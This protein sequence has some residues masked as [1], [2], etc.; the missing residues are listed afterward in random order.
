ME[1]TSSNIN[2]SKEK[3]S[4]KKRKKSNAWIPQICIIIMKNKHT[5]TIVLNPFPHVEQ[6][7]DNRMKKPIGKKKIGKI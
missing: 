5:V 2:W 6:T 1:L 7:N 3:N 4:Y